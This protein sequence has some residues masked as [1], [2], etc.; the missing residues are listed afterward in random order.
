MTD[1]YYTYYIIDMSGITNPNPS[2]FCSFEDFGPNRPSC[3]GLASSSL[4][5]ATCLWIIIHL[6]HEQLC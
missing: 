1:T 3:V 5:E 4:F 2:L 6:G